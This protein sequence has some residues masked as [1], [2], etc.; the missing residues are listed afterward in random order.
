MTANITPQGTLTSGSFAING[1]LGS[2]YEL[3]L[4]GQLS[5]GAD[6]TAFGSNLTG[7]P[8]NATI[9]EFPFTVTGG[10]DPTILGN[11]GG[12]GS[13][14]GA[15]ILTAYFDT[16]SGDTAFTGAWT[17]DFSGLA[18]QDAYADTQTVPEP[19]SIMLVLVGCMV[20]VSAHRAKANK[21]CV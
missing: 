14:Q 8:N 7:Q 3:L 20:F 4:S 21:R 10:D 11:F 19:S 17:S 6:G 13:M 9:F 1:D 5:T 15:I 2:G 16:G 12:L 18:T